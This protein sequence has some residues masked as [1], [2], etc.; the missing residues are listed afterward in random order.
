[1]PSRGASGRTSSVE[2]RRAADLLAVAVLAAA[3]ATF[4]ILFFQLAKSARFTPDDL[5]QLAAVR[6]RGAFVVQRELYNTWSGRWA[7]NLLLTLVMAGG[8]RSPSLFVHALAL[9]ALAAGTSWVLL[10]ATAAS[11]VRTALL[12]LLAIV[13]TALLFFATPHQGDSWFFAFSSLENLV[14]VC[15]GALALACVAGSVRRPWLVG[16]GAL[17]AAVAGGGHECAALPWLAAGAGLLAWTVVRGAAGDLRSRLGAPRVRA[18][19]VVLGVGAASFA[20]CALSPGSAARATFT[21]HAPLDVALA[22]TLL[23]APALL[24]DVAR[25]GAAALL[26]SVV[27]WT[28][29][30]QRGAQDPPVGTRD[31]V[32]VAAGLLALALVVAGASALPG[33]YAL[34]E[35]PPTRAQLALAAYLVA[36]TATFGVVLGSRLGGRGD[37]RRALALAL[38]LATV[39]VVAIVFQRERARLVPD[40]AAGRI[41]ARAYDARMSALAAAAARAERTRVVVEPL[42]PSGLLRSAEISPDAPRAFTNRCL[43]RAVGLATGVVRRPDPPA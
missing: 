36:A 23:G 15:S 43:A 6:E 16:P 14:P 8:R 3:A 40:I 41:Y 29:A 12:P 24:L 31:V 21:R 7:A 28:W 27:V 38:A 30:A 5:C 39:L 18:G 19:L 17:L 33:Y 1:M 13:T 22:S 2:T 26:A 11:R 9:L 10:R 4:V 32:Q 35:A 42:P 37:A 20:V 34:G 25:N